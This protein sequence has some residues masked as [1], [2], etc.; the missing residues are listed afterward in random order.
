MVETAVNPRIVHRVIEQEMKQAYVDYA[1]SV[2]VGRA[3]PDARDGLKP[4][5]RRIL[6]AIWN[7]GLMH[8]KPFKKSA[9]IVGKV[10]AETHPHGD[11]AVYDALVRMAQNFSLRYPL[12]D[13]QGN[14]GSIDGDNAAAY[15][16]TEA[17]LN[18]LAEEMLVDIDKETVDFKPNFDGSLQEPVVLPAKVPNLLVNGSS[19]IAV[20]MATNIPTHNL[21]EVCDAVVMLID[22]ENVEVDELLKILPGP[23]FP[24]GATIVGKSGILEAYKTGK[25]KITVKAVAKVEDD[26]IIITEIPYMVNKSQMIEE[27]AELVRNK[28]IEGIKNIRDESDREGIRVVIELK[29]DADSNVVLNQLYKFS[30]LKTTFGVIFLA[31][32]DNEPKLL[33]LKEALQQYVEHRRIVVRRRTQFELNKASE[34]AHVLEGLIVALD[35]VDDVVKGIKESK[36]VQDAQEFLVSNYELTEV[37]AKAILEMKLS[38]LASLEQ[39]AIR[40]EHKGLL[41]LIEELKGILAS[42]QKIFDIIKK[43]VIELKEKFGDERKTKIVESEEQEVEIEQL[44]EEKDMVV[45]VTHAGYIKRLGVEAYKRQRRGGKGVVATGTKE[46]D[47][48][49]DLFVASTHSYIL[50]FTNKGQVH[51]LKVHEIPEGGR[52]AKGKPVVN[53]ISLAENERINAFVPVREFENENYLFMATMKGTVKKTSLEEFSRPRRGGI[54]AITLDEQDELIGVK[55]TD[56]KR[57]II[58]ATKEGVAIRFDEND[59]RG[60]GRTASGVKG[61]TLEQGDEVVAMEVA[62]ESKSLLTVTEKGFGKR[63]AVSEYRLIGRGGKGVINMNISEKTGKVVDVKEVGENDELMFMSKNGIAIRMAAKDIS[64]IGRATQGVRAMKLEQNDKLV[65]VERIV[66]EENGTNGVNVSNGNV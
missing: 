62:D 44:I 42:E 24:T 12:I 49:E 56:G 39:Q 55:L 64:V 38:K 51:W 21:R 61:I 65:A 43:E 48:V 59:V 32:V 15:R 9:H 36:T 47:F 18:M 28:R 25:G 3:L 11:L 4:V 66:A 31:L 20:G 45:T 6:Y 40:D 53:L 17:R 7:S 26:A 16:Y 33:T 1:M 50:F 41:V 29:K 13:G 35:N 2:I 54:R 10:L 52:Q 58:M 46:E 27:I 8:N 30:R 60:M 22:N 14:W 19:G 5:H 34:R 37:Q 63:T 23:D 57:Q